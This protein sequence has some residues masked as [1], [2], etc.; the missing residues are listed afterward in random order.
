MN[1]DELF[2]ALAKH[3]NL[4]PR[5]DWYQLHGKWILTHDAVRKLSKQ[6]TKD[7]HSVI[8]PVKFNIL[9]DGTV[10]EGGVSGP[11][12]VFSGEFRLVDEAGKTV[13]QVMS[14]GE[15]N[16]ENCK[17]PYSWAMAFKRCFDRGVLDL[18]S[19]AELGV[20]SAT[21]A[22]SFAAAAPNSPVA[23]AAPLPTSTRAVDPPAP[24]PAIP[25]PAGGGAPTPMPPANE[26]ATIAGRDPE[27]WQVAPPAPAAP[28]APRSRRLSHDEAEDLI[29][30]ALN[31]GVHRPKRIRDLTGLTQSQ[32]QRAIASL[33]EFNKVTRTGQKAGT[34][35]YLAG[36]APE[37]AA[38]AAPEA[39]VR[40]APAPP[41]PAAPQVEAEA[42]GDDP[43][44]NEDEFNTEFDKAM[45]FGVT[46][47]D[48]LRIMTD[49]TGC[50]VMS[51]AHEE[52]K[53]TRSVVDKLLRLAEERAA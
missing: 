4:D 30:E 48:V 12:V 5:N 22:D 42:P 51:Q 19:F 26:T 2:K 50:S 20:Y 29:L 38:P 1:N 32:Y 27:D 7:G 43:I 33:L 28:P 16:K 39:P 9:K 11:E 52:G 3:Y 35:Y 21:E 23:T 36:E 14:I 25:T 15:A 47:L 31:S 13:H 53:I 10:S 24:P 17:L 34:Q 8:I 6:K 45:S 41:T 44:V 40:L 18:L 49:L 37:E 46:Y